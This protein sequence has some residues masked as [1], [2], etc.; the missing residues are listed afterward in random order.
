MVSVNLSVAKKNQR[1]VSGLTN[2][3][4][5]T[6]LHE[7]K[8]SMFSYHNF[9]FEGTPAI[10]M[11]KN[12]YQRRGDTTR[13]LGIAIYR[14]IDRQP[15]LYHWSNH[16]E[17]I[18]CYRALQLLSKSTIISEDT[19]CACFYAMDCAS[20]YT[21][22]QRHYIEILR[23]DGLKNIDS[24]RKK[25]LSQKIPDK[26]LDHVLHNMQINAVKP[27]LNEL[28]AEISTGRINQT[29]GVIQTLIS[30]NSIIQE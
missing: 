15:I 2:S 14:D 18:R 9:L 19:L 30:Y 26:E 8:P 24:I 3:L 20:T 29:P 7:F 21:K 17:L 11:G 12:P 23:C 6:I 5:T 27:N 22:T 25:I 1:R 16:H 10:I 13:A 4:E 28:F